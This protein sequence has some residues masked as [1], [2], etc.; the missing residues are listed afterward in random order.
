MA[1][2]LPL[3]MCTGCGEM[4][5]KKEMIRILKTPE[6]EIVIDS[7]GKKNGRGAYLCCSSE[8]L[9]KAI[10]TK[11]LERS[12]KVGIPKELVETLEKEMR[13]LESGRKEDI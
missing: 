9:Q 11:G 4:K 8:C 2:K 10:K 12:L 7:T 13:V 3:R 1:K 6:D 5:A